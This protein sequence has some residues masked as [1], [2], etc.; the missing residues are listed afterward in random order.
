VQFGNQTVQLVDY[1]PTGEPNELGEYPTTETVTSAPGC[2]HRPLNFQ[3]KVDLNFDVA[4]E[5]WKTTIPLH[6]YDG[7]LQA[8]VTGLESNDVIR[9]DGIE[10]QVVGGVRPFND[11]TAP[12]KA[13]IVSKRQPG[14]RSDL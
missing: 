9:V 11:L 6:A 4:T 1:E 13:T 10:Y 8:K 14:E 3:E 2:H 12:F 5:M 7:T